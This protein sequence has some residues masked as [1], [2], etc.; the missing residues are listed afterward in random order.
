MLKRDGMDRESEAAGGF[1]NNA[2]PGRAVRT[3][4][5]AQRST[6]LAVAGSLTIATVALAAQPIGTGYYAYVKASGTH[7]TAVTLTM[8]GK[9][10]MNFELDCGANAVAISLAHPRY[11]WARPNL[12]V[13]SDGSFSYN[14][15]TA[16]TELTHTKRT[17]GR[18]F[19]ITLHGNMTVSGTFTSSTVAIGSARAG[20]CTAQ[21]RA[22]L[23]T[24][25]GI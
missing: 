14:G 3:F 15:W 9:R 2:D 5:R 22:D 7:Q 13:K 10:L 18:H 23:Q 25:G 1:H 19:A 4:L 16:G 11:I 21:F 24:V 12:P 8:H 17:G 20:K 6:A